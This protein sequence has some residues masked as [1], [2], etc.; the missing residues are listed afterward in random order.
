[1]L[2]FPFSRSEWQVVTNQLSEFLRVDAAQ[3]LLENRRKLQRILSALDEQYGEH[4][5]LLET[6]AD[7]LFDS[8]Y[9]RLSKY[10]RAE[11]V[12]QANGLPTYSIRLSIAEICLS[13]DKPNDAIDALRNCECEL[14]NVPWYEQDKWHRLLADTEKRIT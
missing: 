6:E 2:P 14:F 1:M 8:P 3:L 9:K 4:P 11:Y 13:L 12:A 10:R 5:V 7:W